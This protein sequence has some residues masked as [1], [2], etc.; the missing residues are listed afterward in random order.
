MA[1]A[2]AGISGV[3]GAGS[4]FISGVGD[5]VGGIF[6]GSNKA[7]EVADHMAWNEDAYRIGL[8]GDAYKRS[9]AIKYLGMRAGVLPGTTLPDVGFSDGRVRDGR[10]MGPWQHAESRAHALERYDALQRGGSVQPDGGGGG[11]PGGVPGPSPASGAGNDWL[12]WL[13]LAGVAF[14]LVKRGR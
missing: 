5:F 4:S 9:I 12:L 10:T 3:V 11:S 2:L 1:F 7:A 8:A 6:G 14:L 13:A